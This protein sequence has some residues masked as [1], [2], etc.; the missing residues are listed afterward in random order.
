MCC[1]ADKLLKVS[2][3][4]PGPL[5]AVTPSRICFHSQPVTERRRSER[6]RFIFL[7]PSFDIPRDEILFN[8]HRVRLWLYRQTKILSWTLTWPTVRRAVTIRRLRLSIECW[9]H[10]LL[11]GFYTFYPIAHAYIWSA[12]WVPSQRRKLHPQQV[13]KFHRT[14]PVFQN[15]E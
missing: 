13:D 15:R 3:V 8:M 1:F 6:F 14:D 11:K 4:K 2:G 5:C 7:Q 10:G 12:L 9:K